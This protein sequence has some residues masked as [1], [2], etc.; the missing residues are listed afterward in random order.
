MKIKA[1]IIIFAF[2]YFYVIIINVKNIFNYCNYD[3]K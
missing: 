2:I 3:N 1:N